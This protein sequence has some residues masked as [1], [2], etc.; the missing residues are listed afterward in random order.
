[1]AAVM[2]VRGSGRSGIASDAATGLEMIDESRIGAQGMRDG[3]WSGKDVAWGMAMAVGQNYE[4]SKQAAL[5]AWR[6]RK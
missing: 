2:M 1:M 6:V 3:F 5:T 4:V